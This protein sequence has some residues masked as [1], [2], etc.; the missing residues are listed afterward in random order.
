MYG[1]TFIRF[2]SLII[3]QNVGCPNGAMG[4][5]L[6]HVPRVVGSNLSC[7]L[8]DTGHPLSVSITKLAKVMLCDTMSMGHCI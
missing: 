6:L 4:Q 5:F 3:W 8:A 1:S 7:A 2:G